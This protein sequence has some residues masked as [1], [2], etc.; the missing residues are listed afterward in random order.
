M[1]KR[2]VLRSRCLVV[3]A[4]A[5]FIFSKRSAYVAPTLGKEISEAKIAALEKMPS[6]SA[7]SSMSQLAGTWLLSSPK[8]NAPKGFL[9]GDIPRMVL[10]LYQGDIGRMLS[11][12]LQSEP[13]VRIAASGDTSTVT[14]LRWG[15]QED[16]ITLLGQLELVAPNILREKPKSTRSKV[17][18][19]TWPAMQ[20]QRVLNVTYFDENLIIFRDERGIVDVLQRKEPVPRMGQPGG[21]VMQDEE[22]R[23][24]ETNG[25]LRRLAAMQPRHGAAKGAMKRSSPTEQVHGLLEEVQSLSSNLEA[26]RNQTTEDQ[27]AREQLAKEIQR[28]E[29]DLDKAT[30]QSRAD[31]VILKALDKVN[32]K[33]SGLFETQ[34]QKAEEK[35]RTYEDLQAEMDSVTLRAKE[36]EENVMRSR[37]REATLQKEIQALRSERARGEAFRAA[38]QQA[39]GDLKTVHQELKASMKEVARLKEE[40]RSRS[41][42]VNRAQKT[43]ADEENARRKI[44][45]ELLDQ[46][47][48]QSEAAERLAHAH[49]IEQELREELANLRT[50]FE[51]LEQ[52]EV[53]AREIAAG[54]E[55]EIDNL[56]KEAK[57]AQKT[58]QQS[59]LDTR[60]K[61]GFWPFR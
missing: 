57:T 48:G 31:S 18:K 1:A 6:Q 53:K 60:K 55:A 23:S 16:D 17:L 49:R 56:L 50:E 20:K 61:H 13:T 36:M 9:S 35:T 42:V 19:L 45:E 33:V 12:K 37:V 7:V 29:K 54:M 8:E 15:R 24:V 25:R 38:M 59:G 26:L 51:T 21:P 28:L 46:K 52:R 44:E 22:P 58:L 47:Q 27:Q 34:H 3:L 32:Q 5:A 41:F 30:T 39:K 43:A 11:M 4:T 14:K 10:N 40:A 2:D